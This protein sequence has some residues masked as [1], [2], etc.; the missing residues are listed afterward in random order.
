MTTKYGMFIDHAYLKPGVPDG[1]SSS[2]KEEGGA[3]E[4]HGPV[5]RDHGLNMKCTVGKKGKVGVGS[6]HC[7]SRRHDPRPR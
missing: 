7:T 4:E 2:S 3:A 5:D 1:L 6:T